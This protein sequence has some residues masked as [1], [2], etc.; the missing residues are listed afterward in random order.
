MADYNVG[1]LELSIVGI[2]DGAIASIDRVTKSMRSLLRVVNNVLNANF[3]F[4]THKLTGA[5]NSIAEASQRISHI[6]FGNI[7]TLVQATKAMASVSKLTKLE[8]LD[9]EK[10][11]SGFDKMTIA[12]S[13]F[14]DKINEAEVS[15][16]ALYGIVSKTSGKKIQNLL[17]FQA[18]GGGSKKSGFGLL[19]IAKWSTAIYLGKRL[20]GVVSKIAQ[21]GANYT[22]TLNLWETAMGDNLDM[23]TK[24]VDKMNEAYGI[25]EKTL[26]NAQATFK[27][28]LGSLGNISDDMAYILSE[29]VTQMAVDYASL[30]NQTFEQAMY[31]FQ[32]ALAGQV[33]PIRTASGFDITENTLF[34]LYQQLGGDKTMR[35]LN[36]TEKQLLAIYAIF[37]QMSASGAVGDL[38]KTMESYANQARVASEA[39]SEIL[40]YSGALLTYYIQERGLLTNINAALLFM[41]EVLKAAAEATGAIISFGDPFSA[42]TE[43]ALDASAATD[44]LNGKLLDFDKIRAM[45][46]AQDNALGIDE[47]LVNALSQYESILSGATMEAR[48]LA[49]QFKIMS[50]LFNEDGTF[51]LEKW[52]EWEVAITNVGVAL[53]A[54]GLY[55]IS[56]AIWNFGTAIYT[57]AITPLIAFG[58]TIITF[59]ITPLL[60]F[61]KKA[62]LYAIP[63]LNGINM[64]AVAAAASIGVLVGGLLIFA[65]TDMSS[66]ERLI[67]LLASAAAA[68]AAWAAAMHAGYN[69][70]KALAVA[71]LVGGTA[72]TVSAELSKVTDFANGGIPKKGTIFRAGEA[73]AELVH[74]ASNGNTGVT[75][76][77]QFKEAMVQALVEY[78]SMS[79]GS[80]G[81]E[82]IVISIGED[83]VFNATRRRAK[84]EG[85]DFVRKT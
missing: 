38:D 85:L 3:A 41:G 32:A 16:T 18:S 27:N 65:S 74:T 17:D 13:P 84:K 36:R 5:F 39:W 62:I 83:E 14:V 47:K 54:L 10:V 57:Y 48:E 2:D 25:S 43:G 80:D 79:R 60:E 37:Q 55:S 15:L 70:T 35:Q 42:T 26:M 6:K 50:G 11:S 71:A 61:A 53:L 19:N 82:R 30:Y 40:Q 76:I 8:N 66:M 34:Q 28:M 24:F 73:G 69:W 21:E 68:A 31:K 12:I 67:G 44:E 78:G 49:N 23:A 1:G 22:E 46:S 4:F 51:N 56:N 29:G 52:K 64:S 77:R 63:A 81:E 75:N 7:E 33:R 20:G 72:L 9:Y 45:E 58:R 59:A